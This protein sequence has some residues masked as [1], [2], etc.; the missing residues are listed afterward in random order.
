MDPHSPPRPPPPPEGP[1]GGYGLALPPGVSAESAYQ[2]Q[3][4]SGVEP[5][6]LVGLILGV[7]SL[8]LYLCCGGLSLVLNLVGLGLGVASLARV[9]AAP[10]RYGSRAVAI[11]A[12]VVNGVLLLLNVVL[13]LFVFGLMGFGLLTGP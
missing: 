13:M 9:R 5:T 10:D 8:P 1:V 2:K 7:L 11:A 12:L 3:G 4:G 6:G